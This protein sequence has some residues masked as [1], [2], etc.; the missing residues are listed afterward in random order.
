MT[1]SSSSSWKPINRKRTNDTSIDMAI[2]ELKSISEQNK[3]KTE[4][5]FDLFCR[6]IAIQLKK[7]PLGRALICQEKIQ[8]V[9]T[10]ERITQMTAT[11]IYTLNS[12][13]PS[14]YYADQSYSSPPYNHYQPVLSPIV[15]LQMTSP[16]EQDY[17]LSI[18]QHQTEEQVE[19]TSQENILLHAIESI[20]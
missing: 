17:E 19:I 5:E 1:P 2:K 10:Q 9:I 15:S 16:Q 18:P 13:T 8:S 14:P 12:S 6:S 4:D 20:K 3:E 11:S 7:M